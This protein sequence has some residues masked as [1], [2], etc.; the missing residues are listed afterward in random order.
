[1][2]AQTLDYVIIFG[3]GII[4]AVLGYNLLVQGRNLL[5]PD[6]RV[7]SASQM[8]YAGLGLLI[9]GAVVGLIALLLV[10]LNR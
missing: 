5:Q 2:S 3:L 7:K 10:I 9:I 8:I 4:L 6:E 1:M